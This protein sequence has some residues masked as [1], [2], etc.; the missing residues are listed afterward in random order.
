MQLQSDFNYVDM[1]F[2]QKGISDTT[3]WDRLHNS[4]FATERG[5]FHRVSGNFGP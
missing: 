2:Y 4:A 5:N 3:F 1:K